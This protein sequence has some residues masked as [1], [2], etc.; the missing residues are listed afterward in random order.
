MWYLIF[1]A[2]AATTVILSV[3]RQSGSW[4]T[5]RR[6]Q[7]NTQVLTESAWYALVVLMS[8]GTE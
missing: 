2:F 5:V 4:S 1:A 7:T 8:Q 6:G 3:I